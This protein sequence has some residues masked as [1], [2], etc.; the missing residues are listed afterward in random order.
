MRSRSAGRRAS[1]AFL[2]GARLGARARARPTRD[3]TTYPGRARPHATL[4][5]VPSGGRLSTVAP[6]VVG[7]LVDPAGPGTAERRWRSALRRR[8]VPP[9]HVTRGRPGRAVVVAPHPD[10]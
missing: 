10:D 4:P 1:T 3:G 7:P 2:V 8:A 6:P 5:P 9:L